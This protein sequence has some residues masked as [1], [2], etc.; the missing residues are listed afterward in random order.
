MK[1]K[2]SP[3]SIYDCPFTPPIPC[4]LSKFDDIHNRY[5]RSDSA[6]ISCI[7]MTAEGRRV[8]LLELIVLHVL[9]ILRYKHLLVFHFYSILFEFFSF[10]SFYFLDCSSFFSISHVLYTYINNWPSQRSHWISLLFFRS[11]IWQIGELFLFHFP[12]HSFSFLISCMPP[13]SME[14]NYCVTLSSVCVAIWFRHSMTVRN[15]FW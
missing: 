5:F 3:F 14:I 10:V 8:I 7:F 12:A 4:M 1:I 13:I 15:Y 9:L 2:G 6:H 11:F